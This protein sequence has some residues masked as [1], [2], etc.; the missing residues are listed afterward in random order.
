MQKY[1]DKS[2]SVHGVAI[3]EAL[4]QLIGTRAQLI[5]TG[6]DTVRPSD[7]KCNQDS[8]TRVALATKGNA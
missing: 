8:D 6:S 1:I 5:T 7:V 4:R 2:N 3:H